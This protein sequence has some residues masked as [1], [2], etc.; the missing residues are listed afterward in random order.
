MTWQL[1]LLIILGALGAGFRMYGLG[2]PEKDSKYRFL[3]TL[4]VGPIAAA[5]FIGFFLVCSA[6]PNALGFL[7]GVGILAIGGL[8]IFEFVSKI[9]PKKIEPYDEMR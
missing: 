5:S 2:L 8:A 4:A 7:A 6:W 1:W 3:A 9:L